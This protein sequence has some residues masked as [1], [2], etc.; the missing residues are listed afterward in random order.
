VIVGGY[1]DPP[2]I[3]TVPMNDRHRH[4]GFEIPAGYVDPAGRAI[5]H[6]LLSQVV[7]AAVAGCPTCGD[8][9]L[10]LLVQDPAT[11]ARLVELTCISTRE[12]FGGLPAAMTDEHAPGPMALEFR[13]LAR[14]GLN[15]GNSAMFNLR[16][17]MSTTQR[18][19][20]AGNAVS[21]LVSQLSI[22]L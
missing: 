2:A 9:L 22:G 14:T 10:T 3:L 8:A 20:A 4:G 7:G 12:L 13:A 16:E 15:G 6:A 11:T 18:R 5:D 1:P 17:H 19:A 21:L